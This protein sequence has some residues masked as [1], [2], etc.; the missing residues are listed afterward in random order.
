MPVREPPSDR[1]AMDV[2]LDWMDA[3]RPTRE[4]VASL[5]A[6]EFGSLRKLLLRAA[7]EML[8]E[9]RDTQECRDR[10]TR[11]PDPDETPASAI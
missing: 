2:L 11:S 7:G 8:N 6:Q 5:S 1:R 4:W 9:F 3:D 10:G